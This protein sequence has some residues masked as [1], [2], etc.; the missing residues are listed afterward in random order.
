MRQ[1]GEEQEGHP[2]EQVRVLDR[3]LPRAM[4]AEPKVALRGRVLIASSFYLGGLTLLA[5]IVRLTT[6]GVE[7]AGLLTLVLVAV[8]LALPWIQR[9]SGSHRLAGGLLVA[10]CVSVLPTLVLLQG[11]FPTPSL[12]GF[13]LIPLL[14]TFFVG[15]RAGYVSAALLGLAAVVLRLTLATPSESQMSVLAWTF[16]AL[17]VA[18]PLMVA[19][20]TAAY[21]HVH[22][23][24]QRELLA[25]RARAEA[26]SRSKTEFLRG[27]SHEL[28][29]PLNAIIG[30]GELVEEE[31]AETGQTQL[32]GDVERI[33]RASTH[34]LALINDLLDISRVEAGAVDLELV[35][36]APGPLLEQVRDTALPLAAANHN[37]FVLDLA[38]DLPALVTDARRLH[39]ILLNL[40]SNACKF[41]DRGVITLSAAAAPDALI[42]TVRDTG[43]GMSPEQRARLF[44]P[45]VQVH[46]SAERRRQGSGLGLALTR[47]LVQQFGGTIEV[48]SEPGRGSEFSVCLPLRPPPPVPQR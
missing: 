19:R 38:P 24:L 21:E 16:A 44:E 48:R 29:T 3:L 46:P 6:V 9:A 47:R 7:I 43:I 34:L 30:F 28:R 31:L 2:S 33:R 26:E 5:S 45:F 8:L 27:V 15:Q 10:L 4:L 17:A 23:E 11:I 25:A 1:G 39:Q 14:A 22:A 40:V 13:P 32:I 12:L 36:V 41:T 35:E 37:E 20:V 18:V 42:F